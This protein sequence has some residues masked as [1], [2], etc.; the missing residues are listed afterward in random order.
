MTPGDTARVLAKAAAYDLRTVG[1]ADVLAWHE[2]LSTVDF[3]DAL[4]AVARHYADH[5]ERLMPAHIRR[6]VVEIRRD[7]QRGQ[8]TAELRAIEAD[9][10]RRDRSEA[11]R[12]LIADLRYSLPE[13]DPDKL[14]RSEWIEADRRRGRIEEP[15]PDYVGPP[16]PDGHPLPES[17]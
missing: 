10:A 6:I 1:E 5:T 14:R 8:S 13:G 17:A 4:T 16:P 7:R 9:P 15:N 12:S 3:T 2:V 11:V